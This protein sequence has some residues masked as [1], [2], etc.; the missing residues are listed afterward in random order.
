MRLPSRN[1]LLVVVGLVSVLAPVRVR[2]GGFDDARF[3]VFG[4][5]DRTREYHLTVLRPG[6]AVGAVVHRFGGD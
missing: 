6:C 2:Q 5:L 4:D 1:L 3:P